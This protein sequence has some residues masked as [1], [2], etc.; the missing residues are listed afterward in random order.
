MVLT[1]RQ[2]ESHSPTYGIGDHARFRA[3]AAPRPAQR[4]TL[5]ALF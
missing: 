5:V 4:L 1:W 2:H 3:K